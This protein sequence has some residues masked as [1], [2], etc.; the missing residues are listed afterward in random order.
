LTITNDFDL[1]FDDLN[2]IKGDKIVG[3]YEAWQEGYQSQ[4]YSR[5]K[6][7]HGVRLQLKTDFLREIC[8]FYKKMFCIITEEDRAYFQ[9]PYSS[10]PD[11]V[12]HSRQYILYH[13]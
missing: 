6:L 11:E 5:D 4:S 2:I 9:S 13:F 3:R 7:S 1:S 8:A 12:R 10:T